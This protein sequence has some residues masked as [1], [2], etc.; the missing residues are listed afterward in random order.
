V[1]NQPDVEAKLRVLFPEGIFSVSHRNHHH[2]KVEIKVNSHEHV[3]ALRVLHDHAGASQF[4]VPGEGLTFY[5]LS[6]A[7][8]VWRRR[9]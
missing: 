8:A 5:T 7:W 9:G 2:V 3:E 6:T 4:D 1:S